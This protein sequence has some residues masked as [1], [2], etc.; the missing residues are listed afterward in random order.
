MEQEAEELQEEE[1]QEEVE[2]Q[3]KTEAQDNIE[4]QG[5]VEAQD[6]NETQDKILLAALKL[7]AQ[8]G[9]FNTSL[10]DIAKQAGLKNTSAVYP[11]FKNKLAIATQLYAN[12]L[13]SLS[14]SIDDIRRKNP[15]PSA[16]L[17][18]I[19]D[20]LFKLTD[21]A[22]DVMR[23]LLILKLDEFLPGEMPML[24]SPAF[25]KIH[26]IIQ[27]GIKAGEVRN[28]DPV[29]VNAYFFG[30]INTTLRFKLTGMLEKPA[31]AYQAQ[32]WVAAWNVIAKK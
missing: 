12:I 4:P 25:V 22:P 29:L 11:Q 31:D 2:S 28:I 23:F 10:T 18:G 9:F 7:F 17:R 21:D 3:E 26:K 16:Q 5:I 8:K 27:S 24:E 14:V 19:V 15:K 6:K 30:I 13:D 20:L 32:A 1:S